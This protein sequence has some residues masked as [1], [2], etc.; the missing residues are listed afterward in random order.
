[1]VDGELFALRSQTK[2]SED[3]LSKSP[4]DIRGPVKCYPNIVTARIR[5]QEGL[6][7][8]CADVEKPLD[9]ALRDTWRVERYIVPETAKKNIL[10]ELFRLG[11]HA[12]SMFPDI[13]G[14]AARL[15]WQH[16]VAPPTPGPNN[17]LQ[18]TVPPPRRSSETEAEL[19]R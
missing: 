13:D 9:E 4:F 11:I 12:S 19:Q 14:L 17:A 8:A 18:P 15:K 10:Y 2:A 7:I 6:F 1:M 5:A 16:A 3:V